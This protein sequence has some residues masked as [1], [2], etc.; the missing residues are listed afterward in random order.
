MKKKTFSIIIPVYNVKEYLSACVES[1]TTQ[2]HADMEIILV[3]DGS[4]DGSSEL[5]D[6]LAENDSRIKV[7]HKANGGLSSARNV[8][9]AIASGEYIL[10]IDSDDYWVSKTFLE[11]IYSIAKSK[12]ADIVVF[13]FAR[14]TEE[15]KSYIRNRD[16]ENEIS[17]NSKAEVLRLLVI[18]D[19]WQSSA[20]NKMYSKK[21]LSSNDL[22]F[23]GGIFSEDIDW[24]ARSFIAAEKI[25]YLD[26]CPY[27]YRPNDSSIS[28]N[29]RY[30]NI[31]DLCNNIKR[32]VELSESI[33]EADYYEWYMNYCAYQYIT[34][35]YNVASFNGEESI[36]PEIIE[37]KEYRYL[38][39]YHI[40]KKVKMCYLFN[41]IFG[42]TLTIKFLK[43]YL[44]FRG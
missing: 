30:K 31:F 19:K 11:D 38:L 36:K 24:T 28:R 8:G 13:N 22:E 20:W 21:M 9:L 6:E 42:Y 16:F 17:E 26:E 23:V 4:T 25:A 44:K 27:F 40:N 35:L 1:V 14:K 10:F 29:I 41:K 15:N 18:H 43:L 32:I 2:T 39:K 7:V 33:K 34:F 3:D 12:N 37:M 5:C